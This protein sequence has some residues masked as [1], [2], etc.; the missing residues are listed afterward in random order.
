MPQG[1]SIT[2]QPQAGQ[3]GPA[4]IRWLDRYAQAHAAAVAQMTVGDFPPSVR[5]HITADEDGESSTSS[6]AQMVVTLMTRLGAAHGLRCVTLTL[7]DIVTMTQALVLD[8]A[9]VT[10][11][12]D[13]I[14]DD[15]H[16]ETPQGGRGTPLGTALQLW[17]DEVL[18]APNP[19]P[20]P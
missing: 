7:E 15:Y 8:Q 2:P 9:L 10:L 6:N 17:L 12:T 14:L 18:R 5:Q 16:V 1:Y 13:A 4:W 3:H 20:A 11:R 19:P